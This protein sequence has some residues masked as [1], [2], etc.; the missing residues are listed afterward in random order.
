MDDRPITEDFVAAVQNMAK[1]ANSIGFTF[2]SVAETLE[3]ALADAFDKINDE[4]IDLFIELPKAVALKIQMRKCATDRQWHLMQNGS[5]KARK[6]R[7]N[8]LR[9]KVSIA[10]KRAN[11]GPG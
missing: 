11:K 2:R 4:F 5:P 9:K 10:N 8:A 3:T 7:R 6:K 1:V